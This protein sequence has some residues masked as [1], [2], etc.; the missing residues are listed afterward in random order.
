MRSVD[1]LFVIFFRR[2]NF[3][4][5][6]HAAYDS[7]GMIEFNEPVPFRLTRNMQA[8]FSNFGVEGLIVSCMCSAAQAVVSPK[9]SSMYS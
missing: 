3:I 7:N 5:Q 4:F 8:F 6:C 9:V 1:L 2:L